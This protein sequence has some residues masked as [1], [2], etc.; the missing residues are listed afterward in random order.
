[1]NYH[2]HTEIGEHYGLWVR[3][4]NS[5]YF[6]WPKDH[7]DFQLKKSWIGKRNKEEIERMYHLKSLGGPSHFFQLRRFFIH[8]AI[9]ILASLLF[10]IFFI[11][12]VFIRQQQES[13]CTF[14]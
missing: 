13:C 9:L 12:F 5:I 10:I 2:S 8:F 3:P 7:T 1:M 14:Q 11:L 6:Y 4:H